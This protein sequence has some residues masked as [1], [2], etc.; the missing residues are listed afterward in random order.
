[1]L[2]TTLL[3]PFGACMLT[4]W[5]HVVSFENDRIAEELNRLKDRGPG[6]KSVSVGIAAM[7]AGT[8]DNPI[9]EFVA[10]MIANGE[11]YFIRIAL[12]IL[13]LI[14]MFQMY[15]RP[16]KIQENQAPH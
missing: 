2:L 9:N 5:K 13:F 10:V 12:Q 7:Y 16:E 1:M 6:S 14:A 3:L 11:E 15:L 8:V 4:A